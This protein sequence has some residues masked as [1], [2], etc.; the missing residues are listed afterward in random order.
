[1]LF[2]TTNVNKFNVYAKNTVIYINVNKTY[3]SWKYLM[4]NTILKINFKAN[5]FCPY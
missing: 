1:M 5:V 4:A 2:G 3:L